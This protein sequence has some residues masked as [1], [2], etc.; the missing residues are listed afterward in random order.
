MGH[1]RVGHVDLHHFAE[2]QRTPC[3]NFAGVQQFLRRRDER[4]PWQPPD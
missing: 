3:I 2:Y 1:G 4:K